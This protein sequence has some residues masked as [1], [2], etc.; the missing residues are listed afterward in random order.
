[1]GKV[2]I[3]HGHEHHVCANSQV[4]PNPPNYGLRKGAA[5]HYKAV[6]AELGCSSARALVVVTAEVL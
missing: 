5:P 6:Y 2:G 3:R 4:L 1:M